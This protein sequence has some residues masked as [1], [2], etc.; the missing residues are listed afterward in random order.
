MASTEHPVDAC[1][2]P[3]GATGYGPRAQCRDPGLVTRPALLRVRHSPSEHHD[4]RL[5][6]EGSKIVDTI[7]VHKPR[8]HV[9]KEPHNLQP[10]CTSHSAHALINHE[11][12]SL[13]VTDT[14]H[15]RI[16][17][18][19]TRCGSHGIR[20]ASI[21]A[22][23]HTKPLLDAT[24]QT[25]AVVRVRTTL[26]SSSLVLKPLA[27]GNAASQLVKH[28]QVYKWAAEWVLN[29]T[30]LSCSRSKMPTLASL[31]DVQHLIPHQVRDAVL[32]KFTAGL[33][34]ESAKG[35][36]LILGYDCDDMPTLDALTEFFATQGLPAALTESTRRDYDS[37]WR[38]WVIFCVV[39]RK[40]EAVLPADK[41]VLMAFM[42]QLI[43]CQYATGTI[44]KFFIMHRYQAQAIRLP[45]A[46]TVPRNGSLAVRVKEKHQ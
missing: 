25:H 23:P 43:L 16:Q 34:L 33:I 42:S 30:D 27:I 28:K 24:S 17:A 31:L 13:D 45:V 10:Q 6:T 22:F 38:G 21:S 15:T 1:L 5:T 37:D 2:Q 11:P 20:H 8:V 32:A 36:P 7:F 44:G 4:T 40:P 26:H 39:M 35:G 9:F 41:Q 18:P 3:T 46:I 14:H 19:A 12:A 29:R